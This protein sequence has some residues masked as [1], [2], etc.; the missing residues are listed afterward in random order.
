MT[1]ESASDVDGYIATAPAAARPLLKELRETIRAAAPEAEEGIS[2]GMPYYHLHGVRL[3][4]F[5]A[6]TRHVGLYAF[7][8]DDARAVG[9]EKHMAAK[10]TLHFPLDA[11]LPV[12]EIRR[13]I[14]QRV[15]AM[16]AQGGAKASRN[17]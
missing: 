17:G 1:T 8:G 13:L 11:P 10:S 3:T 7:N 6:H 9:L 15:S 16:A 5:Q 2:Y 12:P 14:E 4:Y